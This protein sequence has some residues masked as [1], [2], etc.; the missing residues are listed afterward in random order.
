[1]IHL[2]FFLQKAYARGKNWNSNEFEIQRYAWRKTPEI[3]KTIESFRN[4]S[5]LFLEIILEI[6]PPIALGSMRARRVWNP[7]RLRRSR[8]DFRT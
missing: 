6:L 7:L 5:E 8:S 2:Y 4:I 3:P 1:L